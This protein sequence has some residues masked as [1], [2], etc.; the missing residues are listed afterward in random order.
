MVTIEQVELLEL[1]VSKA[2]DYVKRLTAENERLKETSA[3]LA[4]ENDTL[5]GKLDGYQERIAELEV[6]LLG[7]KKDQERIDQVIVSALE[8]LNLFEDV[9]GET[10]AGGGV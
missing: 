6:V 3:R 8:R 9:V 1:K 4:S 5:S 10:V 2:I 7:F